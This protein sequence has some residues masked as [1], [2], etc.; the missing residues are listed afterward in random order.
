ME[1]EL[2]L[3]HTHGLIFDLI[4]RRIVTGFRIDH[5]DGLYDPTSYL[6]KVRERATRG[7]FRG[8]R[9][10]CRRRV[11]QLSSGFTHERRQGGVCANPL[12]GAA[13]R[14]YHCFG[15]VGNG[16][17]DTHFNMVMAGHRT[18]TLF[19]GRR[20]SRVIFCRTG[21]IRSS[22]PDQTSLQSFASTLCPSCAP[23]AQSR[24]AGSVALSIGHGEAI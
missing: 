24:F 23:A 1:D 4:E 18:P 13:P 7:A 17:F 20:T 22:Q 6:E 21:I 9:S 3:C 14:G 15:S 10:S 19:P 2:V 5:V 11:T 16:V 12:I 8:Q